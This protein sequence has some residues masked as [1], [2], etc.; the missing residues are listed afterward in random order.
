[1]VDRGMVPLLVHEAGH[2]PAISA[3]LALA[4][5]P[6]VLPD[7]VLNAGRVVESVLGV[8]LARL[9]TSR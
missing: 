6:S 1:M 2:H 7:V 5:S 4:T 3:M 8:W 9:D